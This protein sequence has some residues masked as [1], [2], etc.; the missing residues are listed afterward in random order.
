MH[1]KATKKKY[2][3]WLTLSLNNFKQYP[4]YTVKIIL[5]LNF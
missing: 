2:K 3:I 5:D 4:L 1:T